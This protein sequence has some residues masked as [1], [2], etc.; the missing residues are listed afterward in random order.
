MSELI[1][2]GFD[3]EQAADEVLLE[4]SKD[5]EV[6]YKVN[7]E[8][9]AVVI[10][11]ADGQVLIRHT[12]P[13]NLS[14]AFHGSFWGLLIGTLLLNPIAGVITG[15]VAGAMAG[16]LKHIVIADSFIKSLGEKAQPGTSLI[17]YLEHEATPGT[18]LHELKKF[19]GKVI[20]TSFGFAD[21][22]KLREALMN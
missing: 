21:E 22:K 2:V 7:L 17:F 6:G 15:G 19:D 1:V 9:A 18:V 10:R 5:N 20:Q 12:H 3:T 14:H 8:Y 13:L 16:T 11:K 4:L